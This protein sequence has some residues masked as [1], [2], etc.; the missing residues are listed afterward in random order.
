MYVSGCSIFIFIANPVQ[1]ITSLTILLLLDRMSSNEQRYMQNQELIH[2]DH[3]STQN[4]R[5]T[6]YLFLSATWIW[7]HTSCRCVTTSRTESHIQICTLT[8]YLLIRKRT[9]SLASYTD[10][11]SLFPHHFCSALSHRCLSFRVVK[12][13]NVQKSKKK[14]IRPLPWYDQ[15]HGSS[16]MGGSKWPPSSCY[17]RSHLHSA[18][19]LGPR[20]YVFPTQMLW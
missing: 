5:A 10:S 3:W 19:L 1:G 9:T 16:T 11:G 18:L 8:T 14:A 6:T 7:H 13:T 15:G 12:R 17:S 4:Q 2:N 20:R